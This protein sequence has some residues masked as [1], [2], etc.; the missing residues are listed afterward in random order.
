MQFNNKAE[1]GSKGYVALNDI[2]YILWKGKSYQL[3]VCDNYI[4]VGSGHDIRPIEE[5]A[6]SVGFTS[7]HEALSAIYGYPAKGGAWSSYNVNDYKA[8]YKA[9]IWVYSICEAAGGY[10]TTT[11]TTGDVNP[12][13]IGDVVRRGP[14]EGIVMKTTGELTTVAWNFGE[15]NS[16][17]YADF[18]VVKRAIKED[19]SKTKQ[20]YNEHLQTKIEP[21]QGSSGTAGTGISDRGSSTA[22]GSGY[23]GYEARLS[24]SIET[25]RTS[26]IR[27][28]AV[29]Y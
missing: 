1:L 21:L 2:V 16:H 14:H 5:M 27:G 3:R 17:H 7:L 26:K 28:S 15:V 8:A 22:V 23:H 4:Y 10:A 24:E 29:K 11:A 25:I 19:I 6:K 13:N 12:H 9:L 18:I 20:T